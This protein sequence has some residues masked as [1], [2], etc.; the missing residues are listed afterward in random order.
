MFT[1][2]NLENPTGS[3]LQALA[4]ET[5]R[6]WK[7]F[8]E[9]YK[10][11][12]GLKQAEAAGSSRRA[13]KDVKREREETCQI[14]FVDTKIEKMFS[15][16]VCNHRYCFSCMEQHVKDKFLQGLTAKCPH[17]GCNSQVTIHG[18][19]KL[20]APELAEKMRERIKEA[21]IPVSDKFYCPIPKCSALMS[22][23]DLQQ[24]SGTV[25]RGQCVKCRRLICINC[26]VPWH[27]DMT[28]NE[29]RIS[30][31]YPEQTQNR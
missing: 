11:S 16:D 24:K 30:N 14:C 29:Y 2:E 6:V 8:V 21:T 26:K 25:L 1:A 3:S 28:C 12:Q 9:Y 17:E 13:N 4:S 27:Y 20:F 7:L 23:K 22:K 18:C 31:P 10:Q 19:S 5:K 15:I